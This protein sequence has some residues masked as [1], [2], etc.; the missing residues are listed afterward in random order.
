MPGLQPPAH[1]PMRTPHLLERGVHDHDV[2]REQRVPADPATSAGRPSA[3]R[4]MT[5]HDHIDD[6]VIAEAERRLAATQPANTASTQQA[7]YRQY[8]QYLATRR[9]R[10]PEAR[11]SRTSSFPAT[12]RTK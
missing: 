3:D 5:D 10:R 11:S 6:A 9:K 7:T 4:R 2:D 8:E 1:L 12:F